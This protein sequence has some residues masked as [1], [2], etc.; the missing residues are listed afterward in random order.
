MIEEIANKLPIFFT[1]EEVSIICD[2][3]MRASLK[4]AVN[5]FGSKNI[6]VRDKTTKNII[7]NCELDIVKTEG[8]LGLV[9]HALQEINKLEDFEVNKIKKNNLN[10]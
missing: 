4:G 7:D 2:K 5:F 9:D 1:E 8:M 3:V 6:V 10:H